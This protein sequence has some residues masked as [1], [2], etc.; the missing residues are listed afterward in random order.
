MNDLKFRYNNL[1]ERWKNGEK[2]LNDNYT[3]KAH[4]LLIA[5]GHEMDST[6]AEIEKLSGKVSD[7]EVWQGF[8]I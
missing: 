3:M 2:Y 6:I 7:S 1:L 5:I 4:N 8:K